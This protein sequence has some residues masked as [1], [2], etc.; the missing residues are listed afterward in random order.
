MC[1]NESHSV[2]HVI[3]AEQRRMADVINQGTEELMA[4]AVERTAVVVSGPHMAA[5]FM[6][7]YNAAQEVLARTGKFPEGMFPPTIDA[8]NAIDSLRARRAVNLMHNPD[9]AERYPDYEATLAVLP[10]RYTEVEVLDKAVEQ[11]YEEDARKHQAGKPMRRL[12]GKIGLAG[13]NR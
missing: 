5:Q 9:F 7:D 12:L 1:M 4:D 3:E 13:K 6:A 2:A 11:W 8:I 10:V